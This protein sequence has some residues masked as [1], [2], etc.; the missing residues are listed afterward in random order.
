MKLIEHTLNVEP[1]CWNCQSNDYDISDFELES[2]SVSAIACCNECSS[3]WI[4]NYELSSA[5]M[6]KQNDILEEYM[7]HLLKIEQWALNEYHSQWINQVDKL[8][9]ANEDLVERVV[10][11]LGV[12]YPLQIFHLLPNYARL[13]V[14]ESLGWHDD[15]SFANLHKIEGEL[16]LET[17]TSS[18]LDW[19]INV[20]LR[21]RKIN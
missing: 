19:Y 3:E 6:P 15:L 8:S 14:T 17:E 10:R 4:L 5:N 20:I 11:D 12:T 18:D 2:D 13:L 16:R 21:E 9:E 1:N 7:D